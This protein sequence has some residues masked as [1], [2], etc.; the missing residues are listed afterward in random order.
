MLSEYGVAVGIRVA[1]KHLD[2]YLEALGI[3]L[4]RETR[5]TLLGLET[6]TDVVALIRAVFGPE[7]RQA[8]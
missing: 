1:R 2:W 3:A 4:G 7:P 8:A 5:R 6:P